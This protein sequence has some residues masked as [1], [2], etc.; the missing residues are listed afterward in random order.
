MCSAFLTLRE[1]WNMTC[2]NRW[3]NPVLP[4]TS[5]LEPT[6]Y[7]ILTAT[8]GARWSSAMIRRRPLG[9]RSSVKA[10]VGVTMAR[11]VP[12][13]APG[14]VARVPAD[15]NSLVH[16]AHTGDRPAGRVLGASGETLGDGGAG[17]DPLSCPFGQPTQR[18]FLSMRRRFAPGDVPAHQSRPRDG[19]LRPRQQDEENNVDHRIR[20]STRLPCAALAVI[21]LLVGA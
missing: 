8:T 2:S 4:G 21:V 15:R 19:G 6:A 18:G 16:V 9:R 10:T 13:P 3:A 11:R 5:F 12:Q 14:L 17:P 7:Q 1:P 20:S